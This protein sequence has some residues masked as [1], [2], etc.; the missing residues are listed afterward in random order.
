MPFGL[1]GVAWEDGVTR[2]SSVAG[3]SSWSRRAG[4][5]PRWPG[6]LGI[7]DQTIYTWRRQERIDRGLKPGLSSAERAELAAAAADRELETELAVHPS[8]QRAA[9]GAPPKGGSRRSR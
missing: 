3:C 1:E 7:S 2:R 8:G 9:E 4:R 5:S 6:D